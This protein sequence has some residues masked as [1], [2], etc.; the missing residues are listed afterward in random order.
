MLLIVFFT[1]KRRHA[2]YWRDWSSDV[3]SS[4]L[5]DST[6][7]SGVIDLKNRGLSKRGRPLRM[8][9]R[10]RKV[11]AA[12]APGSLKANWGSTRSEERR[13]GKECRSRWSAYH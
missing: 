12:V 6:T 10:S 11:T 7:C 13:V 3:C 9:S 4:D 1:S 2:R 8:L 5:R